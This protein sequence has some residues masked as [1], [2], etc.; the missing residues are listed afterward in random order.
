MN[1]GPG[2][3][4]LVAAINDR[5][6]RVVR[7]D[8]GLVLPQ[9][10]GDDG[11]WS[12]P[13]QILDLAQDPRGMIM[14]P[15]VL[16]GSDPRSMLHVVAVAEDS[17]PDE[18]I[19]L[20]DLDQLAHPPAVAEAIL[21]SVAE[22]RGSSARPAGRPDWFDPNW[23]SGVDGWIDDALRDTSVRRRGP[24]EVIKFWSLSA[25]V[26]VPVTGVSGIQGDDA[27]FFKA[28][29]PWFR[30][31]PAL[32]QFVAGIAGRI[33]ARTPRGGHR[34]WLDADAGLRTG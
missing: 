16:I 33:G 6:L 7:S 28:A 17:R 21:R 25:I 19:D 15:T 4:D 32:T 1:T 5:R 3:V 11:W 9:I 14:V 34:T 20:D 30:A 27:V 12:E 31:E 23:Q 8:R 29:C 22:Y 24:S 10:S 2:T 18:W 26:K 13:P